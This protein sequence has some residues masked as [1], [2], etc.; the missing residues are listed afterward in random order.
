M[1]K[2]FW[3]NHSTYEI[4]QTPSIAFSSLL[5]DDTHTGYRMYLSLLYIIC[6]EFNFSVEQ[7]SVK[8]YL[9]LAMVLISRGKKCQV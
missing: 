6:F 1:Y 3:K 5:S 9:S 2:C 7:D 8:N 4:S